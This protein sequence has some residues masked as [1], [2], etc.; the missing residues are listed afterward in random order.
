[1]PLRMWTVGLCFG[2]VSV[3]AHHLRQATYVAFGY[4]PAGRIVRRIQHDQFRA[5][6][7]AVLQHFEIHRKSTAFEQRNADRLG[8]LHD[9][10]EG[11]FDDHVAGAHFPF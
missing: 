8:A 5:I 3:A 11:G 2:N 10:A 7:Q 9:D 6:R 4:D 1:M